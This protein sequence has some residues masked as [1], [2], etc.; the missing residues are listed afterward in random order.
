MIPSAVKADGSRTDFLAEHI[1]CEIVESAA[2]PRNGVSGVGRRD[3]VNGGY[4]YV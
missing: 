4:R 1:R 2:F 3:G